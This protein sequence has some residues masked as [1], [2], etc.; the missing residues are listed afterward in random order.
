MKDRPIR[1]AIPT[2]HM[3]DEVR[4][5]LAAAGLE[6]PDSQRNY[7]PP[8][9]HPA[10]EVKLLKPANIP[11][12][13]ELGA[14]DAGFCGRDWVAESQV[15]VEPL[16]DT[17]LLPVRIVAAA[18]IDTD[19]FSAPSSRPLVVASEYERLTRLYMER[20]AVSWRFLRTHGATEVFPPEDADLI[21]DNTA[22]GATL[23]ANHLAILDELLVSTTLFIA[24]PTSLSDTTIRQRLEDLGL[25]MR[26]A[27]EARRRV[28]LEMNVA[29]TH[30]DGVIDLLPAMRSPTVQ[31]LQDDGA[32]AVKAAVPRDAVP[33]LIPA[34]RRAGATD[35]LETGIQRVIA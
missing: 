8:T 12:L 33:R 11:A 1:M 30:L 10:F 26:G 18:P 3:F 35:I 27:L 2:G 14:H 17:G 25:L 5:L 4:R 20:R 16:L 21:V 9:R 24:N 31:P 6:L 15:S 13:V 22:T 19:P 29:R 34:L 23:A 32:F 28:L 7:R